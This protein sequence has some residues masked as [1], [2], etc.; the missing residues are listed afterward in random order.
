[1][2]NKIRGFAGFY[3]VID[4]VVVKKEA[5]YHTEIAK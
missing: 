1:M 5:Y 3:N 4:N 2:F